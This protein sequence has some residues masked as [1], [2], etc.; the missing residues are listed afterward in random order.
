MASSVAKRLNLER[1][2]LEIT[3]DEIN[4]IEIFHTQE[5]ENTISSETAESNVDVAFFEETYPYLQPVTPSALRYSDVELIL[6]QDVYYLIRPMEYFRSRDQ[7]SPL[8][9]RLPVVL[10]FCG[11]LS[12]TY[13]LV[14][15]CF[16]LNIE[17]VSLVDQI[18]S[19]YE[20]DSDGAYKTVD[21][22]SSATTERF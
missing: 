5:A 18:K 8:A 9:V 12:S 17:D 2:D 4:P 14:S 16:K 13:S 21:A 20:I 7:T 6:G 22:R 15:A 3:F 1:Q 19:W 10:V 11:Y